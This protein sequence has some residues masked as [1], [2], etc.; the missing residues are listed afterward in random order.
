M[1]SGGGCGG[2]HHKKCGQFDGDGPIPFCAPL[3][4]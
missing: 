2:K 3:L 4:P 1:M